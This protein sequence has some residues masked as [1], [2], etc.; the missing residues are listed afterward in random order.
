MISGKLKSKATVAKILPDV[1]G[2]HPDD[3]PPDGK[4]RTQGESRPGG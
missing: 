3:L 4:M 1:T 2:R